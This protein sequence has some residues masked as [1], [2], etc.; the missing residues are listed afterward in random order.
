[1]IFKWALEDNKDNVNGNVKKVIWERTIKCVYRD[2]TLSEA[3]MVWYW[4]K[5]I[6]NV[7]Q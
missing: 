3:S 1:M 2:H 6:F 5:K 7:S 4:L